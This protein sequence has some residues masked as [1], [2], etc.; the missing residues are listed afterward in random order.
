MD[1]KTTKLGKCKEA[2]EIFQAVAF[3]SLLFIY[4]LFI[5]HIHLRMSE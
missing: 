5:C 1:K 3:V 4:L 2:I